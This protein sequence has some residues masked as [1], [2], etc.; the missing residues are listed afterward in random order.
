MKGISRRSILAAIVATTT[1][2]SPG[3][4]L[5]QA[6]SITTLTK[7]KQNGFARVGFSNF[8]PWG[9]VSDAGEL[10]GVEPA[11]VRAFLNS[12]G[13]EGMD[14]VLT[15]FVSMIP[16]L[17]AER[18]DF[19]AAGMQ[20]RPARCEQI[21]FGEPEWKSTQAFLTRAG[22]PSNLKSLD[23]IIADPKVRLGVVGGGTEREYASIN[24]VPDAQTV[25]FPDLPTATA[26]LKAERVDVLMFTSITGRGLLANGEHPELQYVAMSKP[27]VD[28][29]GAPV[30]GY[31]A[32]GFR[33]S[34]P[35]LLAAWNGWLKQAKQSGE[36]LKLLEPFGFTKDDLAT[37]DVTTAELCEPK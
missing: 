20:I 37:E 23:D 14:G 21:A 36:L 32:I 24:G 7:I 26:G 5:A 16:A 12:V 28:K 33:K 11:V 4:S 3:L 34:D 6:E 15:Q 25:I 30:V 9:Y 35:E 13:V 31:G 10:S 22:N 18:F 1:V 8:K 29:N 2:F 27:P 17:E 19:I